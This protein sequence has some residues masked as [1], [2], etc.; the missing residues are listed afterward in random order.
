VDDLT[1]IVTSISGTSLVAV[2]PSMLVRSIVNLIAQA[3]ANPGRL[4]CGSA[5]VGGSNHVLEHDP[6]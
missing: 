4:T 6:C 2:H 5:G 1:T 3:R